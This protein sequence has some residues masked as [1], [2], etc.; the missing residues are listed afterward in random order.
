[1]RAAFQGAKVRGGREIVPRKI[2]FILSRQTFPQ[3][4]ISA[5]R[6]SRFRAKAQVLHKARYEINFSVRTL[7]FS[8]VFMQESGKGGEKSQQACLQH[9]KRN[10]LFGFVPR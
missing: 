9:Y 5:G 6:K 2:N 4:G 10:F 3:M 7:P 1:A 8:P